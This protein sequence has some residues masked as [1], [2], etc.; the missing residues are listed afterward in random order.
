M[1]EQSD[2]GLEGPGVPDIE[3]KTE[4]SFAVSI[5]ELIG[6]LDP[7]IQVVG[8]ETGEGVGGFE[9]R[10]RL[11]VDHQTDEDQ[12]VDQEQEHGDEEGH[13]HEGRIR[14]IVG[15]NDPYR[16]GKIKHEED[17]QTSK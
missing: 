9:R 6:I 11:R 8:E 7:N 5:K 10:D 2:E 12:S 14:F 3:M 13:E 4:G 1:H 16:K 17:V 15:W